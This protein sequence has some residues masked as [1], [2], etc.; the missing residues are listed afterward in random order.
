MKKA[1]YDFSQH[2]TLANVLVGVGLI[3]IA[4]VIVVLFLVFLPFWGLT[5][6]WVTLVVAVEKKFRK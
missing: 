3:P 4:L 1:D 6:A 5:A 2:S